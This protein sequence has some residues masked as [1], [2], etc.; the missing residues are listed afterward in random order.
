L[1]LKQLAALAFILIFLGLMLVNGMVMLLSPATWLRMPSYLAFH[2]TFRRNHPPIEIRALGFLLATGVLTM[3][4]AVFRGSH[5]PELTSVGVGFPIYTGVCLTTCLAVGSCGM[6]MLLR[7]R[8]WIQKY[9]AG[10]SVPRRETNAIA[11]E[12]AVRL[13]SLLLITPAAYFAWECLA[14]LQ[15]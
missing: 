8:W 6:I 1:S 2:G 12:S 13:L 10:R 7:P 14:A 4:V 9:I 11:M 5:L 3:I 15:P